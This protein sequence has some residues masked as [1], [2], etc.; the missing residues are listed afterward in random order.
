MDNRGKN[1]PYYCNDGIPVI[2]NFMIGAREPNLSIANRFIDDALYSEFIRKYNE[3]NDILITLVGNGIGNLSLFPDKKAV[4]IQNTLGFRCDNHDKEYCY[5]Q[6]LSMNKEIKLL[7]R[8]MAQPSIRQDE[9][10]S[11][12]F[13]ITN[14]KEEKKIAKLLANLDNLITLHQRECEKLK[15]IKKSLLEKMFV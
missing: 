12:Q 1:P 9:L 14:L 11:I 8:G 6:L 3:P 5:Y 10:L 15:N 13:F 7:D 4:I 2:D